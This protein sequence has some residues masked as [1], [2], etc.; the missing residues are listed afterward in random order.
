MQVHQIDTR[1]KNNTELGDLPLL[2]EN[3]E[4]RSKL[5]RA[6]GIIE[7][8]LGILKSDKIENAKAYFRGIA[9]PEEE[10]RD[11]VL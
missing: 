3:A 4:L 6:V 11:N 5:K 7:E 10:L 2:V 1:E 9:N 8:L